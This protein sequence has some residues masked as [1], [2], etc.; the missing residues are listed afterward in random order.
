[1]F[2]INHQK[3]AYVIYTS[4]MTLFIT[5]LFV[6]KH[7]IFNGLLYLLCHRYGHINAESPI[8]AVIYGAFGVLKERRLPTLPPVRAVPSAR[9]GLTSLFGMGRGG[10]PAL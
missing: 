2:L 5:L 8:Y 9:Q 7:S 6:G 3:W 1:M 10:S 4:Y